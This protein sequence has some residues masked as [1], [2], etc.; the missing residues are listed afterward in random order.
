MCVLH[1][2]VVFK[3][4]MPTE[5]AK[6]NIVFSIIWNF[7]VIMIT[8][9]MNFSLRPKMIVWF[10]YWARNVRLKVKYF[11]AKLSPSRSLLTL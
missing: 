9:L 10:I 11:R 3:K 7:Y 1:T 5:S 6:L 2:V 4:A 8:F